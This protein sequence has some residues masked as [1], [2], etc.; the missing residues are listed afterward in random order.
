MQLRLISLIQI[1]LGSLFIS[2][3]NVS[4]NISQ[5]DFSHLLYY[6]FISSYGIVLN[7]CTLSRSMPFKSSNSSSRGWSLL[8]WVQLQ[9]VL[10]IA[11]CIADNTPVGIGGGD[12]RVNMGF[13]FNCLDIGG[14]DSG[15]DCL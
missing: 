12:F 6:P 14:V 11:G 2:L 15:I 4:I 5:L 9:A 10:I 1:R 13:G 7:V 3:N 8:L